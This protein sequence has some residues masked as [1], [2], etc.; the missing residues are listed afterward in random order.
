MRRPSARCGPNGAAPVSASGRPEFNGGAGSRSPS[1][2]P[3]NSVFFY[4]VRG[5]TV[6]SP[7]VRSIVRGRGRVPFLP[8]VVAPVPLV[9]APVPLP[10]VVSISYQSPIQILSTSYRNPI[11]ILSASYQD[12]IN[13][14]IRFLSNVLSTGLSNA[15]QHPTNILSTSYQL[16]MK[17][18]QNLFDILSTS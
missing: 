5:I 12:P 17:S 6:L 15:Y 1:A 2:R 11:N 13:C 16:H 3:R 7:L 18:Y 14:P 10:G 8:F 4:M 9:V